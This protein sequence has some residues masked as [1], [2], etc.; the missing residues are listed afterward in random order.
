MSSESTADGVGIV[1]SDVVQAIAIFALAGVGIGA[2][3]GIAITQLSSGGL[4]GGVLSLVVLTVVLL[5]GPVIGLFSGLRVGANQDISSPPYLSGLVGSIG[6]YFVMILLVIVTL[7]LALNIPTGAA[8]TAAQTTATSGGSST[9]ISF[10]QYILPIIAVAIPT[11]VTGLGGV[12]LGS[13]AGSSTGVTSFPTRYVVGGVVLVSVI[14]AAGLIGPE[15]LSSE[16]QLEVSGNVSNEQRTLFA[17]GTVTNPTTNEIT[18]TIVVEFVIDGELFATEQTEVTVPAGTETE[19][20][21]EIATVDGLS[22]SQLQAIGSR[23]FEIR[24]RINDQTVET[25][26]V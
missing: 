3:G 5:L 24:Y 18:N 25:Y 22:N 19:I 9:G 26:T 15:L 10:T 21:L 23:Q 14:A 17:D 6:G 1:I 7:S 2:T 13:N 20:S 16:P 12:Y 8:D 4:L 11:G